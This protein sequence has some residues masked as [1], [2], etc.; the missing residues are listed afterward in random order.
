MQP[1]INFVLKTEG[2][3]IPI[4]DLSIDIPIKDLSIDIPI[5]DLSRLNLFCLV[6]PKHKW[7][8]VF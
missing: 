8:H 1:K 3:D 5:K 2:I 4:K 6:P 7:D